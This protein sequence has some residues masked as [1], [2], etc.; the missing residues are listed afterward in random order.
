MSNPPTLETMDACPSPGLLRCRKV[1]EGYKHHDIPDLSARRFPPGVVHARAARLTTSL[2]SAVGQP[3]TGVVYATLLVAIC[4]VLGAYCHCNDVLLALVQ[5]GQTQLRPIRVFWDETQSWS[6]LVYS[7][8]DVI[9]SN[10]LPEASLTDLQEILGMNEKQSPCHAT[11]RLSATPTSSCDLGISLAFSFDHT[12]LLLSAA[13]TDAV[14]HTS[15]LELLVSQVG[16]LFEHGLR[17]SSRPLARLPDLPQDLLSVYEKLTLDERAKYYHR[18][19]QV[20]MTT[21]HLILRAKENPN[22][23]ALRWYPYISP[24]ENISSLPFDSLTYL[25]WDRLANRFG[26]W[27]LRKGLQLEDRVAVCM[28]RNTWFHIAFAGILRAGGCYVPIDPELPDERQTFIAKDSNARFVLTSSKLSS[29]GLFGSNAVDT[30]DP[31]E[32]ALI[33]EE[34]AEALQI[35]GPDNLSYLLYTSGTT[36]TPKGCLLTHKG[37]TEASWAIGD[38]SAQV[39]MDDPANGGYLSVASVAFDVHLSEILAPLTTGFPIVSAPRALLLEDLP[40][41]IKELHI[42]HIGIV[43]SLI[44]ATM[45]AVQDDVDSGH[46]TSLRYLASG[47]EKMS[48][49][50]LDKWG[51]HPIVKLANFYGPSEA[52]IGCAARFM[53]RLTPRANIGRTFA[54]VSS[55]VVDENMNIVLR[56]NPGELVVEGPL[57][58]RGYIGRPDLTEKVF[59]D[60]PEKGQGRWAYRTGDL[61]RMMPDQTLEILGRIDTQIKLRGV[62]IESEGISSI[63]RN[64]ALPDL[65]LDVVTV[66]AKHPSIGT[67]QLVTFIAWDASV[68]IGIRKSKAPSYVSPPA[69]LLDRIHEACDQHLASY[70]RPSHIISLNWIPLNPNLKVDAKTLVQVFVNLDVDTLTRAARDEADGDDEPLIEDEKEILAVVADHLGFPVDKLGPHSNLFEWGLDSMGAIKLAAHLRTTF[71][72]KISA[73]D[74]MRDPTARGVAGQVRKDTSS[75]KPSFVKQF[76][77]TWHEEVVQ[78]FP[79][80]QV[81]NVLPPFPVQEGVLSRS[82]EIRTMYVQHVLLECK[83]DTSVSGLRDSWHATMKG[84]DILRTIFFFGR[85]LVQIV[86][87]PDQCQVPWNEK[88]TPIE[89]TESF[90]ED[91]LSTDAPLIATDINSHLSDIPLFRLTL[92][93]SPSSKQFLAVSIHHSLFDGISLP[94]LLA[95]AERAYLGQSL[96]PSPSPDSVLDSIASIDMEKAREHWARMFSGY[97]WRKTSFRVATESKMS[98]ISVPFSMSLSALQRK[99]SAQ[100]TTIQA[101]LMSAYGYLIA[102]SMYGEDDVVFGVIRSGRLLPVEGIDTAPYPL[103]SVTPARVNFTQSEGVLREVQRNISSSVDFEHVPLGRVAQW[104][105]SGKPLFETLFSVSYKD[106]GESSIWSAVGSQNPEPEYILAVEVVLDSEADRLVVHTG[107]TAKDLSPYVAEGIAQ[108][109]E[110]VVLQLSDD[111]TRERLLSA[112]LGSRT[113][114]PDTEG[115]VDV[116]DPISDKGPLDEALVE[117][118]RKTISDFLRLDADLLTIDTSLIGLGLDSIRSVG[119]SRVIRA[120]GYKISSVD[121]MKYSTV[122]RLASFLVN[123]KTGNVDDARVSRS[124]EHPAFNQEL[125]SLQKAVDVDSCKLSSD[126]VVKIF[127][128]TMLQAGM[129]SQTVS[130]DGRRYFHVFP[131]R[132]KEGTDVSRVRESWLKVLQ[133]HSILRT[134]FHFVSDQGVWAQAVHTVSDLKWSEG[135]TRGAED[136][137]QELIASKHWEGGEGFRELP[138]YLHL[139]ADSESDHKILILIMHHALYDGISINILLDLVQAAYYGEAGGPSTQFFDVLPQV[140]REER[141]GTP[142]WLRKLR[143]L[144]NVKSLPRRHEVAEG[145]SHVATHAIAVDRNTIENIRRTAA[146]TIQS[147]TQVAYGKLLA[148][149]TS[150][151]DVIFGHVVSG[152]SIPG[153]ED[154]LGPML[155]T[156]PS[157][158]QLSDKLSNLD[159]T[160]IVHANNIDALP[161]QH[162]SLR[163]IHQALAVAE[164]W[165]SLFV[166]QPAQPSHLSGAPIWEFDT[167][168][169]EI[170][171]NIQYALNVEIHE[172]E[173]GFTVQAACSAEVMDLA[174]LKDAL[175]RYG[176]TL[177]HLIHHVDQSCMEDI[178]EVPAN[179]VPTIKDQTREISDEDSIDISGE[180][181]TTLCD[182]LVAATKM[183]HDHI[184]AGTH[185]IA[186]GVDSITAI[187]IAGKYRR[188]GVRLRAEDI[189][190]SKTVADVLRKIRSSSTAVEAPVQSPQSISASV[191]VSEASAISAHFDVES[192]SLIED[193]TVASPGIKWLIGA[194]QNSNRSRFQHAFAY[195]LPSDANVGK[196]RHAWISLL[197]RHAILRSTIASAASANEPRLVIFKPEPSLLISTWEEITLDDVSVPEEEIATIMKQLVSSPPNLKKPPTRAKFVSA[198]AAKYVILYMNHF[199]YDAWSLPLLVDDFTRLYASESCSSSN[200]LVPWLHTTTA[201]DA[202]LTEQRRYWQSI[203]TSPFRSSFF[204]AL[205]EHGGSRNGRFVH[206]DEHAIADATKLQNRARIEGLSLNA[207]F[208]A[209]WSKLQSKYTANADS[210]FGLWHSGRSA[211][212][213]QIERLAVSCMNVLPMHVSNSQSKALLELA[214]QIQDDL[215]KRTSAVEQTD[216]A[217]LDQWVSGGGKP[218]CNVYVNIVKVAPDVEGSEASQSFFTGLELIYG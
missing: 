207:V 133:G 110:E 80:V 79:S 123:Q 61:V 217:H 120:Q 98:M 20:K 169:E 59:L 132:L 77:Q 13:A 92:Y 25:E 192:Q 189:L 142:F 176:K 47:G 112:V 94:L 84:R 138:F 50:I 18:I 105:R 152:R 72:V 187:Q 121:L 173:S 202:T 139:M 116:E 125:A 53:N 69:G 172:M 155:N 165:D 175:D 49:A 167:S 191:P 36:G 158:I 161:W 113:A 149:L 5:D 8:A 44:E 12:S 29:F 215:R 107:Y 179:I 118:L 74:I 201:K 196:L 90:R 156:I 188:L 41:Y 6:D 71:R 213:D 186:L 24:D 162:A 141:Q 199:Q 108:R 99:A 164:L 184:H 65:T 16:A 200:A 34:S 67:D 205:N 209:A 119:L 26:R 150:S 68:P 48:N 55:Y 76:S 38:M 54:S 101:L 216:L 144:D 182:I 32:Q 64:A 75:S 30:D 140:I 109:M 60:F 40:F 122:R 170:D 66:L 81:D 14:L 43:P 27:L 134:S 211:T 91:F 37:L 51:N 157:R 19:P 180:D 62:R 129:L 96:Q 193:I 151:R 198:Q 168:E 83:Q 130:S 194:W 46:L 203:F 210:T 106:E 127:P 56:G 163:A 111:D 136:Y 124:A 126:D 166:F 190:R 97:D 2:S 3:T 185:L 102:T 195:R 135:P 63:V 218:L 159:L 93:T 52:T 57:V 174:E 146:V 21:D 7:L 42:S 23:I 171:A 89:D 137:L 33:L 178:S 100:R 17:D 4:R 214:H 177:V 15:G 22:G 183:S 70:M 160:K 131:L 143:N 58:G 85:D 154:V 87:H 212:F 88:T 31:T 197:E 28:Q 73:A 145:L 78:T 147:I 1:L 208:L 45:N 10:S 128:T 9:D 153:A 117:T 204:P 114:T 35:P 148:V 11:V 39:A 103:L 115:T 86:L 104:V 206:T 82:S 181:F 95:D